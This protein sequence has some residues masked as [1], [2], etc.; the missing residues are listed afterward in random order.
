MM[1]EPRFEPGSPHPGT[2]G[3]PPGQT[4]PGDTWRRAMSN[5]LGLRAHALEE[6]LQS[7]GPTAA[8]EQTDDLA[9]T[10]GVHSY[11][12]DENGND[13]RGRELSPTARQLAS[14]AADTDELQHADDDHVAALAARL[15]DADGTPYVFVTETP[16]MPFKRPPFAWMTI[17]R[18]GSIT[19]GLGLVCYFLA[20]YITRPVLK[21]RAALRSFG[22]GDLSQRVGPSIGRRRDELGELAR[23]FDKMAERIATLLGA[24]RRLLQDISHEL[25]SPLA[26]QRVAL[27][28]A[29][30]RGGQDATNAL[31]RVER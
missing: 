29:R 11:L 22:E 9:A 4:E 10:W 18:V 24:Q 28:L 1:P 21:L 3:P 20:G 19:I 6:V 23:D 16:E 13:L 5:L 15:R 27:E 17:L 12:L 7:D 8:L 31:D 30:Q 2:P 25:R 26:R 14:R